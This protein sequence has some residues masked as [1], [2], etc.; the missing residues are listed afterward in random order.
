MADPNVISVMAG[1]NVSEAQLN[2][3]LIPF[4]HNQGITPSHLTMN[5][6]S[7]PITVSQK[8]IHRV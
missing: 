5:T 7:T 8:K 4:P 2:I 1:A 6:H 3:N